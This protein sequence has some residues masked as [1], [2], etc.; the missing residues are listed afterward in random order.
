MDQQRMALFFIEENNFDLIFGHSYSFFGVG[1]NPHQ[2]LLFFPLILRMEVWEG[3]GERL[4]EKQ[5]CERDLSIGCLL[6]APNWGPSPFGGR[7]SALTLDQHQL[8]QHSYS[9]SG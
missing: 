5:Q 2:R 3:V 9:Y 6:H 8:G 1:V 4:R 7:A